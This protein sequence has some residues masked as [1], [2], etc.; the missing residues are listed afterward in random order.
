MFLMKKTLLLI[1][2]TLSASLS[3]A[4]VPLTVEGVDVKSTEKG[5]WSG[6]NVL[7][8]APTIFI[9]RNN[10]ITSVN[11]SGYMLQAG[12]EGITIV[13]N[14]LDGEIITGNRFIWNGTDKTSITHGLF[15]GYNLNAIIKY[16]YLDKVPMGIIRKS[17]GMTDVSG[18]VAYNIIKNP[19][20]T[21][22]VVKGMNNVRIYNN[23]FYS[24]QGTYDGPGMGT[25]RGL[26]EIY[27]NDS[28]SPAIPSTG[29]KIKNN[30]FYTK[31]QIANIHI[32]EKED[33][34]GFESDYNVFYCEAGTPMFNYLEVEKTLAQ[35]QALGY[36]RHSVVINPN[37]KN[38]IDFVPASRLDY[39]TNL[40]IKWQTGLSVTSTWSLGVSPETANQNGIW[41]VG[42]RIYK[43]RSANP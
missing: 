17:N 43:G 10:S 39:G 30:I 35:W 41:Q 2:L 6:F 19:V 37:F 14:H 38:L 18:V 24:N 3:F 29:V 23:T 42:A 12:D 27:A 13:N 9:F 40:G 7:R 11:A 32:Y 28:F 36:D 4:Q 31:Y 1:F 15:T 20:S 8:D 26:V 21:G 25:W 22:M 16:N 34:P 33:L 5:E